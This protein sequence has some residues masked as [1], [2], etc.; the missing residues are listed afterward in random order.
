MT[1]AREPAR[2][3]AAAPSVP[4][5]G[6]PAL[7]PEWVVGPDGVL[8]RSAAR[9]ILL[10]EEDRVLLARGH[11]ADQPER[12][13]WFTIGG[14]IDAGESAPAA[15]VRELFEETGLRLDVGDLEGPVLRRSAIFDFYRRPVRQDEV[16]F[17][18]RTAA[19][20][21]LVTSGWTE[22]ERGFMDEVRWWSLDDLERVTVEI[23]PAP[24]VEIVRGLLT[25]WDGTLRELSDGR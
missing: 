23:F 9:V 24:L 1:T 2:H 10:D 5:E 22:V 18:A 14:G 25:G 11:D 20:D 21:R 12:T 15:A 3:D 13:W 16:F 7:G 6:T 8:R 19:T 17:V 4:A